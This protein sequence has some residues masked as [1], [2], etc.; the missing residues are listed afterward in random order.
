M[1]DSLCIRLYI[2]NLIIYCQ[3]SFEFYSSGYPY[4]TALVSVSRISFPVDIFFAVDRFLFESYSKVSKKLYSTV[5]KFT[6]E[7]FAFQTVRG[8]INENIDQRWEAEE[9]DH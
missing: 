9:K 8:R 6:E 1:R 2:F 5:D 4:S 3:L 7:S